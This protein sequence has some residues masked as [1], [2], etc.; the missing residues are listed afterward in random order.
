MSQQI[1]KDFKVHVL[2]AIGDPNS[3]YYVSTG[4]STADEYITDRNGVFKKISGA[5]NAS[6]IETLT[7]IS[8]QSISSGMVV[9]I[10]TDGKVY[11]YDITNENHAGLTCGIAKTSGAVLGQITI[12]LPGNIHVEV[13]S[14]WLPGISYFVNSNSLLDSIAPTTGIVKEIGTGISTDTVFIKN[15]NEFII[16]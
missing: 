7:L 15:Y 14:G 12:T 10:G 1:I 4:I 2:P 9:I 13:G 8:A 16:I 5:S 11:K 3:R 6:S